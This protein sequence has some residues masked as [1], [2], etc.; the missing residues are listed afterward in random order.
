LALILKRIS[1]AVDLAVRVINLAAAY[2]FRFLKC[3]NCCSSRL[4]LYHAFTYSQVS[5]MSSSSWFLSGVMS[6]FV[7]LKTRSRSV[8]IA[9]QDKSIKNVLKERREVI[10]TRHSS[11][12]SHNWD[13]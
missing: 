12:S 13:L 6:F 2:F 11:L 8:D 3:L 7:L 5:I 9:G 10:F 1:L 4:F